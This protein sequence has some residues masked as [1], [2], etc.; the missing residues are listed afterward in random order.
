MPHRSSSYAGSKFRNSEVCFSHSSLFF[1]SL[2]QPLQFLV[3]VSF[4]GSSVL[5]AFVPIPSVLN[6]QPPGSVLCLHDASCIQPVLTN[7]SIYNSAE[8]LSIF[9]LDLG[10]ASYPDS[11]HYNSSCKSCPI[12][13]LKS[14]PITPSCSNTF[15]GCPLQPREYHLSLQLSRPLLPFQSCLPLTFPVLWPPSNTPIYLYLLCSSSRM[16]FLP[17]LLLKSM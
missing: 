12:S 14:Q 16:A 15:I 10:T 3:P 6:N 5:I 7:L 1:R 2:Q 9:Y 4:Q 11:S 17:Y 13:F 8:M